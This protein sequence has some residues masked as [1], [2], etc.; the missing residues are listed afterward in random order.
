M[1]GPKTFKNLYGLDPWTAPKLHKIYKVW[2]HAW[3]QNP[4]KIIKFWSHGRP[5]NP[6]NLLVLEPWMAPKHARCIKFG[7]MDGPK[8]YN[9]IRF[10]AMDGPKTL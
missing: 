4:I 2:S 5:R 1:D 3:P 6:I 10:G 8:P 9:C 7:A